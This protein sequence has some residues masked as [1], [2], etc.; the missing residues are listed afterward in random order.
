MAS[1]RDRMRLKDGTPV[2]PELERKLAVEAER[3]YDPARAVRER[4]GR[5]SLSKTGTSPRV[6]FRIPPELASALEQRA[7]ADD[8]TVSEVAREAIARYL[9]RS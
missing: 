3:G 8:K 6:S 5:P 7:A 2:T 4:V 1:E 9:A